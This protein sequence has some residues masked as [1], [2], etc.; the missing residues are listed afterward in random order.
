MTAPSGEDAGVS[1][2]QV[3]SLRVGESNVG[4]TKADATGRV[5][6][7]KVSNTTAH[8]GAFNGEDA[9]VSKPQVKSESTHAGL[10]TGENSGENMTRLMARE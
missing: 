2:P 1:K 5:S 7:K 8:D 3:K 10:D 4:R 6:I 9:G